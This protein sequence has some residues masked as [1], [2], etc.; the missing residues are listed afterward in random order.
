MNAKKPI[1]ADAL[2]KD[3]LNFALSPSEE[4]ERERGPDFY[5]ESMILKLFAVDFVLCLRTQINPMLEAVRAKFN[6]EI[7]KF[8]ESRPELADLDG[9]IAE[10]FQ[11]YAEAYKRV[12]HAQEKEPS[13]SKLIRYAVGKTFSSFVKGH[14]V[15]DALDSTVN[16]WLFWK[17]CEDLAAVLDGYDVIAPQREPKAEIS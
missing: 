17:M 11:K 12:H 8:C 6:C 2:A 15:R 1:H 13:N 3:L 4:V 9:M 14:E 16:D 5:V 7:D 10:R